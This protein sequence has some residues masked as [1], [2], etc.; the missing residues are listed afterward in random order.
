M[1]QPENDPFQPEIQP[2]FGTFSDSK[3]LK[4]SRPFTVKLMVDDGIILLSSL[5]CSD[6]LRSTV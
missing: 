5:I 1:L 2:N 4:M 3:S 6:N